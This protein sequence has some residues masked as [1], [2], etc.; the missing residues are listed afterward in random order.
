MKKLTAILLLVLLLTGCTKPAAKMTLQPAQLTKD[1]AAIAKLLGSDYDQLL[2]DFK[3]DERVQTVQ[4]SCYELKDGA[5]EHISGGGKQLMNEPEGRLALGFD[6]IPDGMRVA[7]QAGDISGSTSH[8]SAERLDTEDMG[9][10]TSR[11]ASV[12]NVEYEREIPVACQIITAKPAIHSYDTDYFEDPSH[13]ARQGYE[14]VYC[15]TVMF[16]TQPLS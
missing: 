11:M 8:V 2:M 15:V 16:S 4:I 6:I 3:L 10:S 5:W 1:E 12:M 9:R 14:H 13:I 7:V